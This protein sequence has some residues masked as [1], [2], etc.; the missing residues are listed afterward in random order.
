[1]KSQSL[2]SPGNKSSVVISLAMFFLA[3]V[4][5]LVFFLEIYSNCGY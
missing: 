2:S 4:L 5:Q 3:T 1:M